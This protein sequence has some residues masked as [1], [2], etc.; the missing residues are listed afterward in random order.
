MCAGH[1]DRL[2]HGE[3]VAVATA[4]AAMAAGSSLWA[5]AACLWVAMGDLASAAADD[6]AVVVEGCA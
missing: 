4:L 3:V 2:A 5:A 6:E 1:E